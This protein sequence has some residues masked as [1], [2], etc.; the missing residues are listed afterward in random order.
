[1]PPPRAPH[2]STMTRTEA[3]RLAPI[4]AD[5]FEA[6]AA[7]IQRDGPH[8]AAEVIDDMDWAALVQVLRVLAKPS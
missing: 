2:S 4:M 1:M 8:V 5:T 6:L 3:L 7:S